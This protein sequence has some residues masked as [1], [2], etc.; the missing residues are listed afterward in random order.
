MEIL[1]DFLLE[2][3]LELIYLKLKLIEFCSYK[4]K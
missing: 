1:L 2:L 3:N 4:F